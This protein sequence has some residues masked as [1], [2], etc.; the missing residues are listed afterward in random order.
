MIN[1]K[2][3]LLLLTLTM[4]AALIGTLVISLVNLAPVAAQTT[5]DW[6]MW[7]YNPAH[8][9]Y[10][11]DTTGPSQ[12]KL[13]WRYQ[14]GGMIRSSPALVGGRLYIGS[15]DEYLYC[16]DAADGSLRW[17]YKTDGAVCSAPAVV[18]NKVYFGSFDHSVYCLDAGSGSLVWKYETGYLVYSSPCVVDDKV[19][20]CSN[21]DHIY[22]L[23]AQTGTQ[24]WNFKFRSINVVDPTGY[25][26]NYNNAGPAVVNG[27]VYIGWGD[28]SMYC[29]DET[30]GAKIWET[31]PGG[32]I[33]FGGYYWGFR[34]SSSCVVDGAVYAGSIGYKWYKFDAANGTVIWGRNYNQA[35]KILEA[36]DNIMQTSAAYYDGKLYY[37]YSG[38]H[39]AVVVDPATG[40]IENMGNMGIMCRSSCSAAD[41]KIYNGNNDRGFYVWDATDMTRLQS[42]WFAEP[43]ESTPSIAYGKVYFGGLDR[44]IYCYGQGE[45]QRLNNLYVNPS[46]RSISLGT[47][48]TVTGGI[49]PF[50][51]SGPEGQA[52]TLTYV[53][54]DGTTV[55]EITS[56]LTAASFSDEYTPDAEGEWK[57]KASWEG[58]PWWL[59]SES[60]YQTFTVTAAVAKPS[61]T[62]SSSVSNTTIVTGKSVTVSG[63]I[64]PA[65]SGVLVTLTYTKPGGGTVTRT[66]ISGAG[67]AYSDTYKPDTEGSWTVAS[68]W[69][70]NENYQSASSSASSFGVSTAEA[71]PTG[72]GMAIPLE[73]VYAI[74]AIIVIAIVAVV[75]YW[76]MKRSKK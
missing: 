61:T 67:G 75:G 43:I 34:E 26:S 25:N 9:G 2:K 60:Y 27:K 39:M 57:V 6:P 59:P 58:N 42:I 54:P 52:I 62:I 10:N 72:G 11:P 17:K 63:T 46:P 66:S 49:N 44:W 4:L 47:S 36:N 69:A 48:V 30:T 28:G 38:P 50:H 56:T 24:V 41:G 53:R 18:G 32:V 74:V 68:S 21:D 19:F 45:T 15:D 64:S 22:C 14:T 16:L 76:Y 33:G 70:G 29:L 35:L 13:V 65:V 8:T 20:I 73:V 12:L 23:N 71:Q 7:R 37:Q 1:S 40:Y 55:T 5:G 31:N 3:Y 51:E